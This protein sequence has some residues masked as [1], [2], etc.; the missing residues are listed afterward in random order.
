MSLC[1][2]G[3]T[4]NWDCPFCECPCGSGLAAGECR[5]QAEQREPVKCVS[6]RCP[7]AAGECERD[8]QCYLASCGK[9]DGKPDEMD[10]AKWDSLVAA[11]RSVS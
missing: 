4:L 7:V 5:C 3:Y 8:G 11:A 9:S 1:P 10:L 6:E 2:H